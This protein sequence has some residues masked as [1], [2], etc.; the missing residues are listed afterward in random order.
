MGLTHLRRAFLLLW[1]LPQNVLGAATLAAHAVRGS[2]RRVTF[3][4]ERVVVQIAG[5]GAVSLGLFVFHTEVD[6]RFVPVGPE[7]LA[8]ELGHSVQSRWL[9]PLYLPLVGVPSVLRVGYAMFY[10]VRHHRRWG[11]YYDG[12]PERW[13]DELGHV[14]RAQ[15]PRP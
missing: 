6:S 9:G 1:E 10:Q 8:H 3:R 2:V 14:D 4:Q 15:R 11:G 12:Y 13:A 5:D 7:N